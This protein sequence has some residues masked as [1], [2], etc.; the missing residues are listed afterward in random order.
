[1]NWIINI[2]VNAL[3]LVVIAGYLDTFYIDSVGAALIASTILSVLNI[4]LTP[5]LILLTLPITILSLGLFL[6]V[7]NAIVLMIVSAIM[8]E[9]FQ[10]EGFGTAIV[11]SIILSIFHLLIQKAILEPVRRGNK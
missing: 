1:M 9:S 7:I 6:L 11:A 10:I 8:G 3:L 2:F 5:F 4:F